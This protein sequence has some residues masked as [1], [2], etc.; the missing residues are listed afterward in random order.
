[1]ATLDWHVRRQDGV[2]LVELLVTSDSAEQVRIESHLEPVWPPRRQGRPVDGWSGTAY[3]GEVPSSGRLILGF[4]SPAPPVDPPVSIVGSEPVDESEGMAT[5]GDIIRALGDPTP[6]RGAIPTPTVSGDGNDGSEPGVSDAPRPVGDG[7]TRQPT[8]TL[9][10]GTSQIP[11]RGQGSPRDRQE[12]TVAT[13][14]ET[15]CPN[16]G[17]PVDAWLDAVEARSERAERLASV[18][19]AGEARAA[20]E[21][22][23][24]IGAVRELAEQ[25]ETDRTRLESVQSRSDSLGERLSEVD[26][27]LATLER[28]A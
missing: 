15:Q 22:E 8:G 20:I 5:A 21:N 19:A 24:G 12:S 28:L 17:N 2:T 27:P 10:G 7:G 26:L 11:S 1:M 23:G 18:T 6:P 25:L 16:G 9:S 4:A 3:E 13:V 14:H